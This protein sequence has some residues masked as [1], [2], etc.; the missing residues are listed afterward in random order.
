MTE[1]ADVYP[2][3]VMIGVGG[4][5]AQRDAGFLYKAAKKVT[6]GLPTDRNSFDP[7]R[8]L[9][10]TP[11]GKKVIKLDSQSLPENWSEEDLNGL[12]TSLRKPRVAT[13]GMASSASGS[14]SSAGSAE[15][16][17]STGSDFDQVR[18]YTN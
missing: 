2:E 18:D 16:A 12:V 11:G 9:S 7:A 6:G 5:M 3:D 8:V 13:D 4:L 15:S 10:L 17:G 1:A 14:E